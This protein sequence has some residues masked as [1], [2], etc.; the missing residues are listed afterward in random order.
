MNTHKE[1]LLF[2]EGK[3]EKGL[4]I[5]TNIFYKVLN[6]NAF[7]NLKYQE[8]DLFMEFIEKLFTK[9]E[10]IVAKFKNTEKGLP[11][12]IREMVKN[13]FKDKFEN[14]SKNPL[15]KVNIIEGEY[16]K[17]FENPI[18]IMEVFEGEKIKEIFENTLNKEEILILCYIVLEN[19]KLKQ[20]YEEKFFKGISKDAL[21]KR[22]QRLKEKLAKIVKEYNFAEGA[23]LYY[24]ENLLPNICE[25][26]ENERN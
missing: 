8:E 1:I 5:I 16:A 26:V 4:E 25:K 7:S 2:L 21:Y 17:S 14:M 15:D 9:R 20:E 10:I 11:S 22:V 3:S 18:K 6:S 12:Y 13:F 23:V 24:L 19:K